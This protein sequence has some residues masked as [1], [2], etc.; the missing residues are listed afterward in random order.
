MVDVLF[1]SSTGF[2][3]WALDHLVE[4]YTKGL[5]TKGLSTRKI[6]IPQNKIHIRSI[7]G[8]LTLPKSKTAFVMHQDLGMHLIKKKWNKKFK[9]LI[10][11]Y[12]HH[13][14]NLKNYLSL[15]E[16]CSNIIVE[17][18]K[19]Y[20]DFVNLGVPE[21]NLL[22]LPYPVNSALFNNQL[23]ATAP[24][25]DVILVSNLTSRKRPELIFEV[26]KM[27]PH[28]KFTI[29]GKNW[30]K[31]NN[32]ENLRKLPN[33]LIKEFEYELYP[34]ELSNHHLFLSLSDNESGPVPLL[35][36]LACGLRVLATDTGTARDLIKNPDSIIPMHLKPID[37]IGIIDSALSSPPLIFDT[38]PY[39][40]ERS[41]EEIHQTIN[42]LK[43][44]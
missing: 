23:N 37:I 39:T 31:W 12:T 43:N 20:L 11:R 10:L 25:R 44:S 27:A 22:L 7:Q 14:Q 2:K 1:I 34:R 18:K 41:I 42:T 38:T 16:C 36:S 6:L 17:N 24:K 35:E 29:Y 21:K 5:Q 15:I 4:T 8:W 32:F 40:E 28:L 26:I 33:L 9:H 13:N 30:N 3:G 19:N